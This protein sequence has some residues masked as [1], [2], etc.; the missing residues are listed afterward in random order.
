M[1]SFPLLLLGND[2][3][4]GGGIPV[5]GSEAWHP[6]GQRVPDGG[7]DAGHPGLLDGAGEPRQQP[8]PPSAGLPPLRDRL[9]ARR[10]RGPVLR[11]EAPAW[12]GDGP[13][14]T[15]LPGR[16]QHRRAG[17]HQPQQPLRRRL[18]LHPSPTGAPAIHASPSILLQLSP[19]H[20][21]CSSWQ[22]AETARDLNIPI[23]ADEIYGHMVFGGSR[24]IP[25]ASF[26]HLTPVIT[27]GALSKRWMLPGWRLGWLAICDPHGLIKQ[28]RDSNAGISGP[29]MITY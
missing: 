17:H 16:L 11:P 1:A 5:E 15:P 14:P 7:R 26:A 10:R 23:I 4:G 28:V 25:M 2:K 8:A 13:V 29:A 18:L 27:I 20:R 21:E 3:Q 19:I 6:G 9:R 12:L 22:I 24:F